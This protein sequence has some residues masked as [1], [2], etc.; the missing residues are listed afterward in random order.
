[1][2]MASVMQVLANMASDMAAL[3]T[4]VAADMEEDHHMEEILPLPEAAPTT[5]PAEVNQATDG[6]APAEE[7]EMVNEDNEGDQDEDD[8]EDLT[9]S[10]VATSDGRPPRR[11]RAAA[12][13]P[14]HPQTARGRR[15][16][17][18]E[19]AERKSD[20]GSERRMGDKTRKII[21]AAPWRTKRARPRYHSR[22]EPTS[23]RGTLST[24]AWDDGSRGNV[25]AAPMDGA[26]AEQDE[27]VEVELNPAEETGEVNCEDE[28]E[29]GIEDDDPEQCDED[30]EQND[31]T[32]LMQDPSRTEENGKQRGTLSADQ[33]KSFLEEFQGRYGS[34]DDTTV[35]NVILRALDRG[36]RSK[37]PGVR[38]MARIL[39]EHVKTKE[40]VKTMATPPTW[41]KGFWAK[42]RNGQEGWENTDH[43]G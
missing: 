15:A 19:H 23:T 7:V 28:E 3:A 17:R 29:Y 35:E 10:G 1:M 40:V 12:R 41:W 33:V 8:L 9:G 27:E 13:A 26:E 38:K 43:S 6:G 21:A 20:Q 31:E 30:V 16:R 18:E 34:R 42:I 5:D 22:D 14:R 2:V 11:R 24:S 25:A 4:I 39:L 36:L 37:L 32:N